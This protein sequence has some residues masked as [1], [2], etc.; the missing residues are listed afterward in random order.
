MQHDIALPAAPARM[1]PT[2]HR[3]LAQLAFP[4]RRWLHVTL[5]PAVLSALLWAL[6]DTLLRGWERALNISM[7]A[8]G[9]NGEL[10]AQPARALF[11][12]TAS[13]IVG[14][15]PAGAPSQEQLVV[16]A[17]IAAGLLLLSYIVSAERAPLR[18]LLR[19]VVLCLGASLLFFGPLAGR[20]PYALGD[21]VSAGL[22]M[23]WVFMLLV[24]WLHAATY[25]IFG[26]GLARKLLLSVL[27]LAYLAVLA[28]AQY[29]FH[30]AVIQQHSLL[31]LP[32]LYLFGGVMLE[33]MGFVCL[34][35]WAMS[36]DAPEDAA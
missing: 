30:V 17:L 8:L 18:Y 23:T 26:F 12:G 24:P 10:K 22:T 13:V 21:H 31:A 29:L 5:L 25:H 28:P 9:L 34:Y 1:V 20:L 32:A 27:T 3:S 2:T 33:V 14:D 11:E 19:A 36:W 16:G 35:A 7:P 4:R 15:I 6:G